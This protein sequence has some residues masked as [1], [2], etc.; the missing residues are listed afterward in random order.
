[1]EESRTFDIIDPIEAILGN[2][3]SNYCDSDGLPKD[4]IVQ[5][6]ST[7][8]KS[9]AGKFLVALITSWI[10]DDMKTISHTPL[11]PYVKDGMLISV[12]D[13]QTYRDYIIAQSAGLRKVLAYIQ[14]TISELEAKRVEQNEQGH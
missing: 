3:L 13:Q 6:F 9:D 4:Y 12:A 7:F 11:R 10:Y 14:N 8:M 2:I 5:Q 1:M